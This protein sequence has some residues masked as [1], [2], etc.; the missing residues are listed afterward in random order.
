MNETTS[1]RLRILQEQL[2]S[3]ACEVTRVQ[4]RGSITPPRWQPR[5]NAYRCVDR[6]VICV[7]LAGID[8]SEIDLRAEPLRIVLRG[9]RR[10]P[11]PFAG[12]EVL[13]VLAIEIDDGSWER[14]L[15]LPLEILPEDVRAVQQ[16]GLLWIDLPLRAPA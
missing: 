6:I 10:T 1:L 9:K 4:F 16:N 2:S 13:Q 15:P 5:L 12:G 14:D 3:I 7:D 8:Q 11:L